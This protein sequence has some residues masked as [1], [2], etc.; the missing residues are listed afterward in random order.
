VNAWVFIATFGVK[1]DDYVHI[2]RIGAANGVAS[3]NAQG[4]VPAERLPF[5]PNHI[6]A[7]ISSRTSQVTVNAITTT[8][9]T[10]NTN[11]ARLT[12][13]RAGFIDS[14]GANNAAPNVLGRSFFCLVKLALQVQPRTHLQ[15]LI[16]FK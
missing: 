12:A 4:F 11:A 10:I 8:I 2:K 6:D 9:N 3:L 7:A 1:L 15:E 5:D 13:A 16:R 14:I